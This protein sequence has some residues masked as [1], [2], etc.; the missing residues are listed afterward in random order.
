MTLGILGSVD[1]STIE[2]LAAHLDYAINREK[3]F[4]PAEYDLASEAAVALIRL[5]Q[6]AHPAVT[7]A[8]TLSDRAAAHFERV[9]AFLQTESCSL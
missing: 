7:T 8:L 3:G 4:F 5:G 6:E 2:E 9:K 1:V